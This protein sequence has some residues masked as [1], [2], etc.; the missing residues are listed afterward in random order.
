[1]NADPTLVRKC[2]IDKEVRFELRVYGD[3]QRAIASGCA[4]IVAHD[5]DVTMGGIHATHKTLHA[6]GH[7]IRWSQS[8][9]LLSSCTLGP[10][11]F[12]FFSL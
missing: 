3:E 9:R 12:T 6:D 5:I 10:V 1:M 4:L 11:W 2:E 8:T 7:R